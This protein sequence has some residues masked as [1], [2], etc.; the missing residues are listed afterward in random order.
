VDRDM[1]FQQDLRLVEQG[2]ISKAEFRVRNFKEKEDV[3]KAKI[4]EV[5][6]EQRP[7]EPMLGGER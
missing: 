7:E 4:A 6:A 1:Q 3:A 2:I 5:L